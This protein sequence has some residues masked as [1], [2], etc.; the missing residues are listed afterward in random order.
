[1]SIFLCHNSI[2]CTYWVHKHSYILTQRSGGRREIINGLKSQ[3]KAFGRLR[4]SESEPPKSQ[5]GQLMRVGQSIEVDL[6]PSAN[7]RPHLHTSFPTTSSSSSST[8]YNRVT[9]TDARAYPISPSNPGQSQSVPDNSATASLQ[10][11]DSTG[12]GTSKALRGAPSA[13]PACSRAAPSFV[14]TWHQRETN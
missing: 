4:G 9:S 3:N 13:A 2:Q 12:F 1:M 14:T 5:F 8:H 10:Q 7:H 11:H 6:L